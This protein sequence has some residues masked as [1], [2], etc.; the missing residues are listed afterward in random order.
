MELPD[1]VENMVSTLIALSEATGL[2]ISLLRGLSD[3]EGFKAI[4]IVIYVFRKA[5]LEQV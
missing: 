3:N 1:K 4:V 2:C 5:L